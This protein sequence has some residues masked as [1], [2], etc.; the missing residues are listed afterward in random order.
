[1]SSRQEG[2]L[3]NVAK[4]LT[5]AAGIAL[6]AAG[7]GACSSPAATSNAATAPQ[8]NPL[9][10]QDATTAGAAAAPGAAPPARA[11]A[12]GHATVAPAAAGLAQFDDPG[13]VTYSIAIAA[14]H[15]GDG[16]NLPDPRCTPGSIDPVVTQANIGST[17]CTSGYTATIRPPESQTEHAKFDVS[18]PAYDLQGDLASELDHLVPLELGGSNDITNLWPEVGPIP[19]PKDAVENAL[20]GAVCSGRVTLAA[21]RAAIARDWQTSESVLGVGRTVA[22]PPVTGTTPVAKPAPVAAAGSLCGAP[23]NPF[24][25]TLCTGGALVTTPPSGVC[26]Y[27]RCIASF[28]DGKG[29]MTECQDGEYSMSGGRDGVCTDHGGASHS[30][31]EN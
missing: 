30:V 25:L 7:G 3:F 15:T 2:R 11:R 14:C 9:N 27:F 4:I 28:A 8:S 6:L 13:N 29:Y 17:I 12:T 23:A 21:A 18:Y 20:N 16:G 1:M 24:H 26:G 22:P 19:N 10:G 5:V 31:Y